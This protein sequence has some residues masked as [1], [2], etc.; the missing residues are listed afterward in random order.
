MRKG[1]AISLLYFVRWMSD[2]R[3]EYASRALIAGCNPTFIGKA[4][5]GFSSC[6]GPRLD[7]CLL[8]DRRGGGYDRPTYLLCLY[9]L[10]YC[11][12]RRGWGV[13]QRL[14]GES[15]RSTGLSGEQRNVNWGKSKETLHQHSHD[16][17]IL[18]DLSRKRLDLPSA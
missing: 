14:E 4:Q 12:Q 10:L 13:V 18:S 1:T 3:H 16:D 6:S 5:R 17:M 2:D 7:I 8:F 15:I 11:A 9:K